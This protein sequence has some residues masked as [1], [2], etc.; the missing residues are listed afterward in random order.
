MNN[1][2][3]NI[4][5]FDKI[6]LHET[7][8]GRKQLVIYPDDNAVAENGDIFANIPSLLNQHGM[9]AFADVKDGKNALVVY[10][11]S[12]PEQVNNI[13]KTEGYATK[14]IENAIPAKSEKTTNHSFITEAEAFIKKNSLKSAAAVGM[15]GHTLTGVI[16]VML[17]DPARVTNGVMYGVSTS[18]LMRYGNSKDE[19]NFDPIMQ[20]AKEF[21]ASE[22]IMFDSH[23]NGANRE[24]NIFQKLEQYIHDNAFVIANGF[25]GVGDA[26]Q[27]A[28]GLNDGSVGAGRIFQGAS[29]LIG[30]AAQILGNEKP[31]D[32]DE[33]KGKNFVERGIAELNAHPLAIAGNI[34]L[35]Q[36]FAGIYDAFS[37]NKHYAEVRKNGAGR[38]LETYADVMNHISGERGEEFTAALNDAKTQIKGLAD[39]NAEAKTKALNNIFSNLD[40]RFGKDTLAPYMQ[41]TANNFNPKG[42]IEKTVDAVS[43]PKATWEEMRKPDEQKTPQDP[44]LS[45]KLDK[46]KGQRSDYIAANSQWVQNG[47]VP[48][49]TAGVAVLYGLSSY[50]TSISTKSRDAD[51]SNNDAFEELYS[52]TAS[53]IVALEEEQRKPALQRIAVFLA[54]N[55]DVA[56]SAD[57][58]IENV[59]NRLDLLEKSPWLDINSSKERMRRMEL[60]H[61]LDTKHAPKT[62]NALDFDYKAPE[63]VSTEKLNEYMGNAKSREQEWNVNTPMPSSNVQDKQYDG[64]F[65]EASKQAY[66]S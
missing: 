8:F 23:V 34:N 55:P 35:F 53:G 26:A 41:D 58:I 48:I 38:M 45:Q 62:P 60:H 42:I 28:S 25:G 30:C 37:I 11:F 61:E 54:S 1:Q 50:L 19:I 17:N 66:I 7:S 14:E 29:S 21:L 27:L 56:V 33:M 39:L 47:V 31:V 24:R 65:A 40:Q 46:L 57:N 12:N 36:N 51:F 44:A 3:S 15:L 20:N 63:S 49:M 9:A 43:H 52:R 18:L 32:P 10:G 13:F 5:L 2:K 64:Q 4:N 16:G 6:E 22:G 59:Q